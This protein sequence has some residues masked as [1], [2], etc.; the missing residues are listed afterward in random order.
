M[1]EILGKLT[2]AVA[3]RRY[4]V[5]DDLWLELLDAESIP[6]DDLGGL[7]G[8]LVGAGEGTRALD[9]VLALAPEL[10][11]A[12]RYAEAS[13]LLHAI[14]PAAEGNEDVRAGLIDCYRGLH[15]D[16]RH[17]SACIDRSGILTDSDLATAAATLDK[18]LSRHEGDYFYHPSG[19]GVG[20]I[21]SFDP[22]SAAATIDFEHKPGHVVPLDTIESIFTPLQPDDL[23]VL[24]KTDPDALRQLAQDDPAA[25]VR[26]ALA[27]RDGRVTQRRLRDELHGDIVPTD[28]WNKWWTRA[29]AQLRRDPHVH[30]ATGGNPLLTL[31]A[32]ALTYEDEMRARFGRLKDLHHQTELLRGYKQHMA[33]DAD[34]AAFLEPAA[35]TLAARLGQAPPPAAAFEAA[36]LLTSLCLDIGEFPSPAHILHAQ[37]DPIPLLSGLETEAARRHAMGILKEDSD[38]WPEAC[39]DILMRGPADLWD[40]ALADLPEAGDPPTRQSLAAELR[41]NPKLNL[42]LFSWLARGV[43]LGRIEAGVTPAAFFELLLTE[44]DELARRKAEQRPSEGPFGDMDTLNNVRQA[45]RA[46]DLGYFDPIME[47]ASETEASRLLFRV[48]QSSVLTEL[49]AYQLERKI[50]RR[51]PRLLA[52]EQK[53]AEAAGPELIYAT[54]QAI[55]RRRTEHENLVNVEIPANEK[56]IAAAAAMGDISDNAD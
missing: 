39:R 3:L 9:L 14:A 21:T 20:Q 37:A 28:E 27:A 53:E 38:N 55:E 46:G 42:D 47:Q 1:S 40:I 43:L 32:E 48:R 25:L 12:E 34:P 49:V 2:D 33:K 26:K 22:L 30:I 4:D 44:G 41:D 52:E 51:Y 31:R 17:L 5:V 10:V 11:E 19:W 29:R 54:P 13:P 45:I 24:R 6:A 35:E 8:Q 56:R 50:I 15:G 7:I 16:R 18:F 23:R 36:L